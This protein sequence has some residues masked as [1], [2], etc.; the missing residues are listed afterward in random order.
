M[1]LFTVPWLLSCGRTT[2]GSAANPPPQLPP[3]ATLSVSAPSDRVAISGT[4]RFTVTVQNAPNFAVHWQVNGVSGGNAP[5]G[6]ID[7]TGLYTAP[8][9]PRAV[10]VRAVLVTDNTKSAS[11]PIEVVN[12]PQ[13]NFGVFSWRND[14]MLSGVNSQETALTPATVAAG[15]FG[16]LFSCPVDGH[17]YAQPLY[18]A[19]LSIPEGGIHDVVFVATEHN[20]VYAFDADASPCQLLWH[21]NF[22]DILGG[23]PAGVSTVP[24]SDVGSDDITP[25]FEIT[26][27][28]VIDPKTLT[29]YVVAKTK[30]NGTYVQRL[31]ALDLLTGDEKFGG[32]ATIEVNFYPGNGVGNDGMGNVP[33]NPLREHQ[34]AGLLLT[35]GKIYVAFGGHGNTDPFHGWLISYDPATLGLPNAAVSRFNTTPNG[36]GGGIGQS[37]AAPAVGTDGDIFVVTGNGDFDLSSPIAPPHNNF[38]QTLVRIGGDPISPGIVD[39]FTP[40]N[41]A[42]LSS[43]K[44]DFGSSG[45]LLLPDQAGSAQHPHLAVIG[46]EEGVL[47]LVDRDNLGGHV[48]TPGPDNVVDK[49]LPQALAGG[50]FGTPVYWEVRNNLYVV[51]SGDRLKAFSLTNASLPEFADSLT[52]TT[53]PFP[54][55]SPVISADGL[56]GG[57]VWVLD[58]S[59]FDTSQPAVLHAYDATDLF[60]E[61]YASS[62]K[63]GD[64]AGPAVKFAV[65]T[66]A[67]GKVYVGTQTELTV[68]GL[69]P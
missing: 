61:L 48:P 8:A 22:V 52:A 37:G 16:K 12:I 10:T 41:E 60:V 30:E 19:D 36:S 54:G 3:P 64:A 47:Y 6:T 35:G 28:P 14:N 58:T 24:F 44:E 4:A 42:F 2:G 67:N 5:V 53:F 31:H 49:I 34:H 59:G 46:S 7:A 11:A 43:Q 33:F 17:V 62:Q 29:F 13:E 55:A 68:Y 56:N 27:T 21:V 69:L 20:S 40:F 15:Q 65:P 23:L 57:I 26:G 18:V 63:S 66:V 39:T 32:P 50:I 25:E 45:V 51:A 1:A 9:V 38:G